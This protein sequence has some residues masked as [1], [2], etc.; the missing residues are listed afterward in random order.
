MT[1]P[2]SKIEVLA[3]CRSATRQLLDL[4]RHVHVEPVGQL[5]DPNRIQQWSRSRVAAQH[6]VAAQSSLR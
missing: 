1:W 5:L 2:E 4:A 3:D 6:V